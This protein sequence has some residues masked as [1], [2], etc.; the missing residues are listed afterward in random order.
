MNSKPIVLADLD[1][2]LFQSWRKLPA[3]IKASDCRMAYIDDKGQSSG[4]MT[5]VQQQMLQ[6]LSST[7]EL[8]PVTA[9][10]AE[11]LGRVNIDF[12]SWKIM[13]QGA[14]ILDANNQPCLSWEKEVRQS[15]APLQPKLIQLCQSIADAAV[16]SGFAIK[17]RVIKAYGDVG[18]YVNVKSVCKEEHSLQSFSELCQ[19]FKPLWQELGGWCHEN[20]NNISFFASPISKEAAVEYLL[21][22]LMPGA[23]SRVTIGMGDSLTD[24]AFMSRCHFSANPNGP[25]QIANGLHQLYNNEKER[26]HGA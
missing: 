13:T 18:I 19:P 17:C 24:L 25:T 23:S 21:T 7:T 11:Q 8:I 22:V 4:M 3:G 16:R 26:H 9:R 2:T 5:P 1:D 6:W 14:V 15:V 12:P 10:S 20:G